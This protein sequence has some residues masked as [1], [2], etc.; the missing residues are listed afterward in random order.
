[1]KRRSGTAI[2][3]RHR[4]D[5]RDLIH[6][7]AA[8]TVSMTAETDIPMTSIDMHLPS[9]RPDTSPTEDGDTLRRRLAEPSRVMDLQDL[10]D[11]CHR[12]EIVVG[13]VGGAD[14]AADPRCP[15]WVRGALGGQLQQ[16]ASPDSLAGRPCPWSPPCLLDVL[17][18]GHGKFRGGA[19]IP[20][21]YVIAVWPDRGNLMVRL[22]LFGFV[23]DLAEA[24]AEALVRGLR[25]GLIVDGTRREMDIQDRRLTVHDRAE[26]PDG[27]IVM[28]RLH[29]P[30]A[31]RHGDHAVD[32]DF[33]D[34]VSSLT[35][36]IRGMARW[37]DADIVTDWPALI[38]LA[39]TTRVHVTQESRSTWTRGSRRQ[40]RTIPM[41]GKT[42]SWLIDSPAPDLR[43]LLALGTATH[44]GGRAALGLGRYSL[45]GMG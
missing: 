21:P 30:L 25:H 22:T 36:R 5:R 37:H 9:T 32:A 7:L 19:D 40:D 12:V 33:A 26:I 28:L 20:K 39:R 8:F 14:L 4:H 11:D 15:G 24:T 23:A 42:A 43:R 27:V 2:G 18:G 29:T 45:H 31:V 34:L 6:A 16:A 41:A 35:T 10:C 1:M 3:A 44:A 17:F 13:C 38:Q